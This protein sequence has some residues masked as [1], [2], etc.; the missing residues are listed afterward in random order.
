MIRI[1][2]VGVHLRTPRMVG[3]NT[4]LLLSQKASSVTIIVDLV[5]LNLVVY[6]KRDLKSR[7]QSFC[8]L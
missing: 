5:P 8:C 1:V 4:S 6:R 7:S 2:V 3:D